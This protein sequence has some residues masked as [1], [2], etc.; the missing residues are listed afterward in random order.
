MARERKSENKAVSEGE[1]GVEAIA[2]A[3]ERMRGKDGG[4]SLEVLLRTDDGTKGQYSGRVRPR[5][6][7]WALSWSGPTIRLGR[8]HNGLQG[9]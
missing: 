6:L 3:V 5:I 9:L 1:V 4:P 8:R 7:V 2:R